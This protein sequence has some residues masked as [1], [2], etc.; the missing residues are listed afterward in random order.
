MTRLDVAGA[1]YYKLY[2]RRNYGEN[3]TRSMCTAE[4]AALPGNGL[5]AT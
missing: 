4:L 1:L 3:D 5:T 2:E